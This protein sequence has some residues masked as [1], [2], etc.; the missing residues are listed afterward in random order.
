M[1]E[2]YIKIAESRIEN[3][4]S[5]PIQINLFDEIIEPEKKKIKTEKIGLFDEE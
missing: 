3:E 4:G 2:E 5:K 1:E